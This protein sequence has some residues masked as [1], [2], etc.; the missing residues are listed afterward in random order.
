MRFAALQQFPA[1]LLSS[2]SMLI[3]PR[4]PFYRES[5]RFDTDMPDFLDYKEPS[6]FQPRI[7]K[8]FGAFA[9]NMI[10]QHFEAN[11]D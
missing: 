7:K 4:P 11:L 8:I 2:T 3:I 10:C 9:A 6:H 1:F 5:Y